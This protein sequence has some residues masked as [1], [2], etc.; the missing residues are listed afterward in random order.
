MEFIKTKLYNIQ[1]SINNIEDALQGL[2]FEDYRT[3]RKK[4]IFVVGNI[5]SIINDITD[6]PEDFR[7]SHPE[8][9]WDNFLSLKE[10]IVNSEVG[11][12][13][14]EIWKVSKQK[15]KLLRKFI[16]SNIR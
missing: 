11:V 13:E 4:M 8:M 9:N 7:S 15:L 12:N 10:K 16:E 3:N 2:A 1:D 14:E 5:E 6:L